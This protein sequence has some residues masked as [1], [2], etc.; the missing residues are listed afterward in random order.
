M[1]ATEEQVFYLGT[2]LSWI[3]VRY[4]KRIYAYWY[5]SKVVHGCI[6]YH[7]N[8]GYISMG[9]YQDQKMWKYHC[10]WKFTN[11][12]RTLEISTSIFPDHS[13]KLHSFFNHLYSWI[14][15]IVPALPF[16]QEISYPQPVHGFFYYNH[17]KW[18]V[19]LYYAI[20]SLF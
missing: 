19:F 13:W 6:I 4:P 3:K 12:K 2:A 1:I 18:H 15:Q 16:P 11:K 14:L 7:H 5:L 10:S 8:L 9:L 17:Q 20:H